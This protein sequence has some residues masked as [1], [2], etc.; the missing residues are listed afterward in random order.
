MRA[1]SSIKRKTRI[2]PQKDGEPII[3]RELEFRLWNK[4]TTLTD[5]GKHF[6]LFTDR[7]E[8][9]GPV[10]DE[11]RRLAAHSG[12]TVEEVLA[13]AEALASGRSA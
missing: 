2:I 12:M 10:V 13:E 1:V 7:L 8:L 5:L 6:K 9:I 11:I 4:P 3:E